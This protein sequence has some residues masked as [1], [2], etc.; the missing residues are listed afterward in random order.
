MKLAAEDHRSAGD[1]HQPAA[2]D[3]RVGHV[4]RTWLAVVLALAGGATGPGYARGAPAPACGSTP[5][6]EIVVRV[7]NY[8][9]VRRGRLRSAEAETSRIMSA[10]GIR[11]SWVGCFPYRSNVQGTLS[12]AAC[13]RQPNPE[14][15]VLR[16]LP[17]SSPANRA[18]SPATLGFAEGSFLASALYGHIE[19]F[20]RAMNWNEM[21]ISP[22]LG[23]VIAHELGHLLLGSTGHSPTGIMRAQWNLKSMGQLLGGG[24]LFTAGQSAA[25]R[26]RLACAKSETRTLALSNP[27]LSP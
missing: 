9:E 2:T 15:L 7:Y 19:D 8:A 21:E 12:T 3:T 10:A 23:H 27:S 18:F 5:D 20:V 26:G 24:L 16:I 17:R 13:A 1:P 14:F 6:T 22:I 11:T 4:S 25:L